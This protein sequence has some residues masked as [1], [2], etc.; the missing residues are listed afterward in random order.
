MPLVIANRYKKIKNK[1]KWN[2][3]RVVLRKICIDIN[4]SVSFKSNT[5]S[6]TN[7]EEIS[8]CSVS[9]SVLELILNRILNDKS[10]RNKAYFR[11]RLGFI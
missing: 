3:F 7:F 11:K 5:I 1:N 8:S 2:R 9:Y 6:L 4:I 10:F